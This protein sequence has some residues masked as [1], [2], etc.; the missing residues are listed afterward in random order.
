MVELEGALKA[1]SELH[2]ALREAYPTENIF[3]DAGR[4]YVEVLYFGVVIYSN[5]ED[6]TQA[7]ALYVD[8]EVDG[9]PQCLFSSQEE[10]LK[11]IAFLRGIH[12]HGECE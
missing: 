3:V 7:Y 5:I 2:A 4:Y 12:P 10:L 1:V 6:G 9:K 11:E 8:K